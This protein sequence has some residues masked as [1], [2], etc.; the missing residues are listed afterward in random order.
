MFTQMASNLMT[1]ALILLYVTYGNICFKNRDY[2]ALPVFKFLIH[3][4]PVYLYVF[5]GNTKYSRSLFMDLLNCTHFSFHPIDILIQSLIVCGYLIYVSNPFMVNVLL[6]N[7]YMLYNLY[8]VHISVCG[9]KT[10]SIIIFRIIADLLGSLLNYSSHAYD[11][12]IINYFITPRDYYGMSFIVNS[13]LIVNYYACTCTLEHRLSM[14]KSKVLLL[15]V[16]YYSLIDHRSL[17]LLLLFSI[18][19]LFIIYFSSF[20]SII[21]NG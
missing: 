16:Y 2:E 12:I 3:E 17:L 1:V 8:S 6:Q 20:I 14:K 10:Y 11:F 21:E 4:L 13:D 5:K 7:L 9:S 15:I 19:Y 18:I